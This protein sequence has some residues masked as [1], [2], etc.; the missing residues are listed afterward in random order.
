MTVTSEFD[1]HSLRSVKHRPWAR[2]AG[3]WAMTQTWLDVLFAHWTV[4]PSN[5]RELVP[6]AF[7]L[8]L[9]EDQAWVSIVPFYMTNV[10]PR[11]LPFVRRRWRFAELNVRTY[12]RVGHRPGVYFFSLDAASALA[13]RAA[14]A[15]LNLPYA[16][17]TMIVETKADVVHYRS[18]RQSED[19]LAEFDCTYA[20]TGAAVPLPEGSLAYFLTER[21][22]LYHVT[23]D[24]RP[25]RLEI[26][27]PPWQ[28][29]AADVHIR[30]NS[31]ATVNRIALP[32][33]MPL[34]H[35]AARQD[36]V[37][38]LPSALA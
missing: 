9:F 13:V 15:W 8:D 17:A 25:Y 22:C 2:P 32:A 1:W 21:Y 31:M 30:R 11:G 24:G 34:V 29:Q 35:Y 27:H 36:V 26:H 14:R 20:G 38:W 23:S 3:A 12:V 19:G 10:A 4:D 37:A 33:Q 18:R 16:L 28:I 6:S 7:A 5:L